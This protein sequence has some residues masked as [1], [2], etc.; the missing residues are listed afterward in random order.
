MECRQ[1]L[2]SCLKSPVAL[3][4][5]VLVMGAFATGTHIRRY[6]DIYYAPANML[7]VLAAAIAILPAFRKGLMLPAALPAFI[8]LAFWGFIALSMGWSSVPYASLLMFAM[9]CALPVTFFG[10]ILSPDRERMLA[11]TGILLCFSA[12]LLAGSAL[13]Q[14]FITGSDYGTRAHF[15]YANPN[16]L[17]ALFNLALLP[18]LCFYLYSRT[19]RESLAYLV[20]ALIFFAALLA[21]ESRGALLSFG[22]AGLI[23]LFFSRSSPHSGLKKTALLAAGLAAVTLVFHLASPASFLSE[24]LL[25]SFATGESGGLGSRLVIWQAALMMILERPLT[26][27]GYGTFF[28]YYPAYR[29]AG[30][31][32]S[33]GFWTHMDPL[34]FWAEMGVIAPI[35]FYAAAFA[36]LIR[37]VKALKITPADS[38]LRPLIWAGFTALLAV[39]LHSHLTFNFYIMSL[40]LVTGYMLALWYVATHKALGTGFMRIHSRFHTILSGFVLAALAVIVTVSSFQAAAGPYFLQ[41]AARY[42]A[43]FDNTAYLE[44][45]EKAG[46]WAPA[47]FIGEELELA[48]YHISLLERTGGDNALVSKKREDMLYQTEVLLTEA[49]YW[50]PVWPRVDVLKARLALLQD[51]RNEAEKA[52]HTALAKN[53]ASFEA[54]R[55]LFTLYMT[56]GRAEDARNVLIRAME[57][58]RPAIHELYYRRRLEEVQSLL[59]IKARHERRKALDRSIGSE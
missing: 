28:L 11:C 39:A 19:R 7:L 24:R 41:Q 4:Y 25:Q 37:T 36:V 49:A 59:A 2:I 9:F 18:T 55:A 26:G 34:Q 29:L 40:L 23:A 5:G 30:D 52:L 13:L 57:Y 27:T 50:N 56:K 12:L 10:I 17:A 15:P 58:P 43:A 33:L 20:L 3:L 42:K 48:A 14:H 53:P 16:N 22:V 32:S 45:L 44:S 31:T 1:T 47:S 6:E 38:H 46:R 21:T 35:L 54:N 51:D 8:I